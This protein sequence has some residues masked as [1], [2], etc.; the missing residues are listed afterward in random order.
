VDSTG[1][2]TGRELAATRSS[3]EGKGSG[4]NNEIFSY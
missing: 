4:M 2:R 1:A 3:T